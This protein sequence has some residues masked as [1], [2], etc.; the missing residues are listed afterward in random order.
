LPLIAAI[1]VVPVV[2]LARKW[3]DSELFPGT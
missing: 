1:P 2:V 3:L